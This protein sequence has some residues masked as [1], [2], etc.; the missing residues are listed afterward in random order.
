[1]GQRTDAELI[2]HHLGG[3]TNS[4]GER[5]KGELKLGDLLDGRRADYPGGSGMN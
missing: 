3:L 1:M 4:L 5:G 2:H